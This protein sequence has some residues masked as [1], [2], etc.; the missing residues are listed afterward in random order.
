DNVQYEIL[1][2]GGMHAALEYLQ[3]WSLPVPGPGLVLELPLVA[4]AA[5]D[6]IHVLLDGQGGNEV[7]GFSPY[8]LADHLRHGRL[9]SSLRLSRQFPLP[10]QPAPWSQSLAL[11][12]MFGVAPAPPLALLE[13]RRRM[14]RGLGPP[15]LQ[16]RFT[17]AVLDTSDPFSWRRDSDGPLS[18]AYKVD[19]LL[20]GREQTR[21]SEYALHRAA[22]AGLDARPPLMDR[23]LVELS[24]TIPPEL[25]FDRR[26]DRPIVREAMALGG[27]PDEVR[28]DRKKSDLGD[29][30]FHL[31]TVTDF[32]FIRS[33]LAD[34]DACLRE[35][36]TPAAL[37]GLTEKPAPDSP[38]GS[39]HWTARTWNFAIVETFLRHVRDPGSV[40]RLLESPELTRP[41]ARLHREHLRST[42]NVRP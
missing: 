20:R 13:L 31:T 29:F 28:L 1:P 21:L 15:Y 14:R 41:A 27:V 12:R 16:R 7:F 26:W 4:R 33:L 35:Y 23:S 40:A 36:L 5:A 37:A 2:S 10:I 18:W 3:R 39:R 24:L 22:A 30:Y 42:S 19:V 6:G 34:R 8:V 38:R 17:D 25:D 11:W 32:P 9:A